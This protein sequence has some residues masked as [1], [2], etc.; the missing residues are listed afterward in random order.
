MTMNRKIITLTIVTILAGCLLTTSC[1]KDRNIE[2]NILIDCTG[3][4]LRI[5]KKDYK[6]CNLEMT[7]KYTQGETVKVTFKKIV[8]CSGSA[9]LQSV[10]ELYHPF[11]SWTEI[12]KIDK[13]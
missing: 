12:V 13:L 1:K 9:N 4:Y 2:A 10:C 3:T 6:V 11:E 7:N 8:N 5:N